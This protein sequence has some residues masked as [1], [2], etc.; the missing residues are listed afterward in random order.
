MEA[1]G[2]HCRPASV[3]GSHFWHLQ[4]ADVHAGI[5]LAGQHVVAAIIHADD[6]GVYGAAIG[7]RPDA[8]GIHDHAAAPPGRFLT[9]ALSTPMAVGVWPRRVVSLAVLHN[10][11]TPSDG[12][13]DRC[14][15]APLPG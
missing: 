8:G 6:A 7:I 15:S 14:H 12:L 13:Q 5:R 9:L 1:E 2:A 11:L 10:R 4:S 3:P